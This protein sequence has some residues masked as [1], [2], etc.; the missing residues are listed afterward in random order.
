MN[1]MI[2]LTL[3]ALAATCTMECLGA[4]QCTD[5]SD[6]KKEQI[7]TYVHDMFHYPPQIEIDVSSA[8]FVGETC[9]SK[10]HFRR[11]DTGRDIILFLSPDHRFLVRDLLDTTQPPTA[12]AIAA[13]PTTPPVG[14]AVPSAKLLA[15]HF[16]KNG[17]DTAP[18]VVTVFSDFQCPFCREQMRILREDFAPGDL[19]I[20]FRHFP[21]PNHLWAQRAAEATACAFDQGDQPFWILHDA[22]FTS[23]K[24]LNNTDVPAFVER[25]MRNQPELDIKQFSDCF[26]NSRRTKDVEADVKFGLSIGIHATPTFFV[27]GKRV[28]GVTTAQEIR[29]I[30]TQERH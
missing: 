17:P 16:P 8:E 26:E 1:F 9:F 22:F 4:T 6:V 14:A 20:V 24:E 29:K 7:A 18:I 19:Q 30:A 10:I 5:L 28:E 12:T 23:Q 27:N 3:M 15:G 25:I 2:R 13:A 11:R 21:L